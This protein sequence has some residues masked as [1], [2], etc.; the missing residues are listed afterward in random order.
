MGEDLVMTNSYVG[1]HLVGETATWMTDYDMASRIQSEAEAELELENL[2]HLMN[3]LSSLRRV[4]SSYSTLNGIRIL[5]ISFEKGVR[6]SYNKDLF[7][8]E[9]DLKRRMLRRACRIHEE[10]WKAL[11]L[12]KTYIRTPLS[13]FYINK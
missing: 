5:A 13:D 10:I 4:E 1:N 11:D 9:S 2:L 6:E 12:P 3:P 7:D 8:I